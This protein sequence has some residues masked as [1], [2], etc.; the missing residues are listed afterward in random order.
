MIRD[1]TII[2]PKKNKKKN[3]KRSNSIAKFLFTVFSERSRK[4]RRTIHSM[5]CKNLCAL[6]CTSDDP[7]DCPDS[8]VFIYSISRT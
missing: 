8:S 6:K 2:T 3:V 4:P 7:L 5:K 1:L